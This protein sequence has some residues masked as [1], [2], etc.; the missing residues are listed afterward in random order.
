MRSPAFAFA[1]MARRHMARLL[2]TSC[3]TLGVQSLVYIT[4]SVSHRSPVAAPVVFVG[5]FATRDGGARRGCRRG[6]GLWPGDL[7]TLGCV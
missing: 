4:S 1:D 2:P 5:V 7:G 6:A 3:S